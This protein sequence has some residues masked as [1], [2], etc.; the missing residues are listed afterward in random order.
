VVG[1]SATV[2]GTGE[3]EDGGEA[4]T[5]NIEGA[6]DNRSYVTHCLALL[7]E[8]ERGM[9]CEKGAVAKKAVFSF[10]NIAD[11]KWAFNIDRQARVVIVR[12]VTTK[13]VIPWVK[14]GLS[15]SAVNF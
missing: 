8:I 2:R 14:L 9:L 10:T 1:L 3:R 13:P 6:S 11:R 15:P 5:P 7:N 12:Y 4:K